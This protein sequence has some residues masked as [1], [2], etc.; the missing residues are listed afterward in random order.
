MPELCDECGFLKW[1][2]F[3]TTASF[4]DSQGSGDPIQRDVLVLG[5]SVAG[6]I[7][8]VGQLPF[9]GTATYAGNAIGTVS[10]DLFG[11]EGWTTYVATG[12]RGISPSAA[13]T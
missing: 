13:G 1:G 7:P 12:E 6:D 3:V 10:T 11:E 8:P 4:E 9:T 5:W 2:A